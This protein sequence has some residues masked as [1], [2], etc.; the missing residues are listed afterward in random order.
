[1]FRNKWLWCI[2]GVSL[3]VLALNAW[4]LKHDAQPFSWD[5]S[6][7]YMGAVG[8]YKVLI[9]LGTEGMGRLLYLSDFYPPLHEFFTGML[10][11]VTG[12]SPHIA[13]FVNSIYLVFILIIMWRIGIRLGD[14]AQGVLAGLLFVASTMVIAQSKF[15]MLDIPLT[16]WVLLGFWLFLASRD[17][18]IRSIACLYGL[19]LGGALLNKWSAVFFLGLPPIITAIRLSIKRDEFS[20]QAWNNLVWLYGCAFIIAIPW[21]SVHFIKLVKSSSGLLFARGVLENDPPLWS[22]VSWF[23]YIVSIFRQMSWGLGGIIAVGIV[24]TIFL[25]RKLW[26]WSIWLGVPYLVLTFIRNKD[27]RYTLPLLPIWC[28]MA[29]SWLGIFSNRSRKWIQSGVILLALAQLGYAHIGGGPIQKWITYPIFGIPFLDV[30]IPNSAHWPTARIL[31]N[32]QDM[33]ADFTQR[34]VLRVVPDDSHFSRVTFVVEQSKLFQSQVYLSGNTN[35]PAFTDFVITKTGN[36]GLPFTVEVPKKVTEE[37]VASQGDPN[38]RFELVKKYSLP[39]ASEALLFMRRDIIDVGPPAKILDELHRDLTRLL[40]NYIRDAKKITIEIIPGSFED[41]LRGHFLGV[42]INVSEGQ[43]GDF[44]HNSLGIPIKS[45]KLEIIDLVLDLNESR[46]GR[47]VPYSLGQ[48]KVK[49]VELE[50]TMVNQ[51]LSQTQGDIQKARLFFKNQF[52]QAQWLGKPM[53]RAEIGFNIVRDPEEIHSENL[54]FQV[55]RLQLF[56]VWWP[57]GWLQPFIEDFNPIFKLNGFPGK[58]L[59]GTIKTQQGRLLLGTDVEK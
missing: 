51:V 48:L 55:K 11:V 28:V 25:R 54:V 14:E 38:H 2:S 57:I 53:V 49:H 59:L 7:H 5:E 9:H 40:A 47:L 33:G 27:D 1:M 26:I 32:V 4:W 45:L 12:P 8:Y 23:F 52:I 46:Q 19:A 39:D 34:P 30:H 13:A 15:F 17:F 56:S 24:V 20:K 36:L 22:P 35:W 41:T 21:Y 31:R 16:F 29:F 6:I 42:N 44:Q 10:F 43:V 58:I 37:L 50:E 18:S 3:V